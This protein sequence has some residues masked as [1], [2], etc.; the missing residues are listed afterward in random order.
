MATMTDTLNIAVVFTGTSQI[1]AAQAQLKNLGAN[2]GTQATAQLKQTN[3]AINQ[4]AHTSINATNSVKGFARG[5]H[6]LYGGILIGLFKE[7]YSW[8]VGTSARVTEL[9]KVGA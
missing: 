8:I 2:A 1:A 3:H 4:V 9:H 5:L 7:V 6:Y